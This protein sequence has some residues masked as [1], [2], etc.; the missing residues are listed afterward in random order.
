MAE[1]HPPQRAKQLHEKF[2]NPTKATGPTT[3]LTKRFNEKYN[4]CTRMVYFLVHF[5][6]V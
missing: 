5:F 2:K 4:G 6:A 3:S 1:K